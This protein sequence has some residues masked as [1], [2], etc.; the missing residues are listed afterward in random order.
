MQVEVE[1]VVLILKMP[2]SKIKDA[3]K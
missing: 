3:H 2:G 1:I